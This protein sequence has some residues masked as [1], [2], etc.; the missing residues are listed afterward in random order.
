MIQDYGS[1]ITIGGDLI[2][3]GTQTIL[4][5][6]TLI[7]E[8]NIIELR[9][10]DDLVANDGGIQVNLT[11]DANGNVT[12]YQALQWY[13]AGSYWRSYDGSVENRFVTENET[14]VLTNKTLTS[15]T[16]TAPNIGAATAS[17][18]N[19]LTITST[20]SATLTIDS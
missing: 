16:L 13:N 14:Q 7:V 18:I 19:G 5:T 8:D 17:S 2:V 4:E 20:A 15:P 10:G 12:S 3:Q 9:K 1:A 11:T 6:S